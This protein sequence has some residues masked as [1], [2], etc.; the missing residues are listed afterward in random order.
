MSSADEFANLI[1]ILASQQQETRVF[2]YG[3]IT[4][5]DPTL[6]RVRVQF[7]TICDELGNPA[8]SPWMPLGT[9]WAGNGFGLQVAPVGGEQVVVLLIDNK[10]GVQASATMTYNQTLL[11]PVPGLI[12]GEA[13]LWH[14]SGSFLYF[15]TSGEIEMNAQ[16]DIDL[17]AT[18]DINATAG[19]DVNVMAQDVNVT[20]S[21]NASITAGT[22]ANITAPEINLGSSGESLQ[23][24]M[25]AAAAT[26]YNS[27]THNV[28]DGVSAAP[29]QT[30]G[31]GQLTSVIKGG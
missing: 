14:E 19:G 28:P 29:N 18:G 13:V 4:N 20:A 31:A 17:T 8:L 16:G 11:P 5:Y 3:H 23:S 21:G 7:P 15:H 9:V 27:H 6:Q 30:I 22:S 24:M 25:T 12:A 10:R 1:K 26:V 2:A